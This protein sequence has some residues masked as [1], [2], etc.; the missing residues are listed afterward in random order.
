MK[1]SLEIKFPPFFSCCWKWDAKGRG[2]SD[3]P[4]QGEILANL[5]S[6]S[7]SSIMQVSMEIQKACRKEKVMN[8]DYDVEMELVKK[9]QGGDEE[10]KI[11]LLSRYRPLIRGLCAGEREWEWEDLKSDLIVDFLEGIAAFTPGAGMYFAAYIHRR[12]WWVK[13][14]YI[15]ERKKWQG[16]EIHGLDEVKD[17]PSEENKKYPGLD[18]LLSGVDFDERE[19]EFLRLYLKGREPAEIM[20]KLGLTRNQ[21][22]RMK[23]RIILKVRERWGIRVRGKN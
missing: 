19:K 17:E 1:F 16:R 18:L 10:A 21:Y 7:I 3:F 11:S 22:Y 14:N 13:V 2:K 23:E 12:L 5:R 4:K 8:K 9:A 15:R 20:K 6:I